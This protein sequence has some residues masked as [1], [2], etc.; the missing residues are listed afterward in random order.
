METLNPEVNLSTVLSALVNHQ[1]NLRILH[2]R[3]TGTAFDLSHKI[4]EEY[5]DKFSDYIDKVAEMKLTLNDENHVNSLNE[6]VKIANYFD[7]NHPIDTNK[8][9]TWNEA[10]AV[11]QTIFAQIT[12]ILE[13]V[14]NSNR[15]PS[16]INS[17]LDGMIYYF[18][19]EGQ[20]KNRQR[21]NNR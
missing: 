14:Q 5:I 3:T 21:L 2:W 8:N 11:I 19:L 9:Y 17:E 18:R 10:F 20:Y 16:Y 13:E 7:L 6:L 12:H 4:F 15:Y 1:Y